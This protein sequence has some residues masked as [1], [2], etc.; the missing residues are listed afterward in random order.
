MSKATKTFRKWLNNRQNRR[1]R[2]SIR[3]ILCNRICYKCKNPV[4]GAVNTGADIF[5]WFR[6]AFVILLLLRA[7]VWQEKIFGG[8]SALF[9]G[10]R[11]CI[12]ADE[13]FLLRR[14]RR[15]S[16]YMFWGARGG[17]NFCCVSMLLWHA[18][19]VSNPR[20]LH[21]PARRPLLLWPAL[22]YGQKISRHMRI[23]RTCVGT[24]PWINAR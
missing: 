1:G 7:N 10:T 3:R 15:G 12:P 18:G 5:C 20:R 24:L 16:F 13:N 8:L 23:R 11:A 19:C 9:L 22:F 2:S 14:P 21:V 6:A 4:S 17:K